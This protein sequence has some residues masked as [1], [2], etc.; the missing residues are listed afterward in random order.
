MPEPEECAGWAASGECERNPDFMLARCADAC[1]AKGPPSAADCVEWAA[2]GECEAN[3]GF[4]VGMD[5]ENGVIGGYCAAACA[6]TRE[7][8]R[9][10]AETCRGVS[11]PRCLPEGGGVAPPSDAQRAAAYAWAVHNEPSDVAIRNEASTPVDVLWVDDSTEAETAYAHLQP[12]ARTVI[13]SFL[14]HH[15]RVRAAAAAAAATTTTSQTE[16]GGGASSARR[17]PA[18]PPPPSSSPPP[19]ELLLDT[20]ANLVDVHSCSCE[21][22]ARDPTHYVPP[23]SGAIGRFGVNQTS[24]VLRLNASVEVVV[25][26]WDGASET[27]VARLHPEG[28]SAPNATAHHAVRAYP[29]TLVVARRAADG[30][31]LLQHLVDDTVVRDS[32]CAPSAT[33]AASTRGAARHSTAAAASAAAPAAGSAASKE[34]RNRLQAESARLQRESD[35]LRQQLGRLNEIDLS[36]VA[37]LPPELLE[38]YAKNATAALEALGKLG[39]VRDDRSGA[40][41]GSAAATAVGKAR[42]RSRPKQ[43]R[44]EL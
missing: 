21:A 39:G 43:Q 25:K 15:W 8:P 23:E 9:C 41:G 4:M 40:A 20:Y 37:Q 26:L 13:Q 42:K 6:K 30:A 19:G 3:S 12:G 38:E 35:Q 34:A 28:S 14:G 7:R 5:S 31:L 17:S 44:D 27:E 10:S 33:P 36:A 22:H 29:G 2:R 32:P 24:R 1:A 18:P 16:A 11:R